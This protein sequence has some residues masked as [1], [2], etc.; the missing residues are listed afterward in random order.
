MTLYENTIRRPS[1]LDK[2]DKIQEAYEK[3]IAEAKLPPKGSLYIDWSSIFDNPSNKYDI[4]G[5]MEALKKAGAKKVWVDN[6]FGWS[7]Q[8]QVVLFTGLDERKAVKALE[9]Y[10]SK[11]K[12]SI[13]QHLII[14]DAH[15]DWG[16]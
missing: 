15:E 14:R 11:Y 6:K 3:M 9:V 2:T 1:N 8:P 7:N 16:K 12:L 4:K 5:F 10:Y 13:F